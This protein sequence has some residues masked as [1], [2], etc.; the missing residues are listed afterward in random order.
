MKPPIVVLNRGDVDLFDSATAVEVK[1]EPSHVEDGE[2]DI[3][4]SKGALLQCSVE[5]TSKWWGDRETVKLSPLPLNP[6]H[7]LELRLELIGFFIYNPQFGEASSSLF[8][9]QIPEL[10]EKV[11][12]IK[13]VTK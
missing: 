10:L 6:I 8:S 12:K 9:L 2:Y 7:P 4:D 13:G 1:L 5:R 11:E 3:Y